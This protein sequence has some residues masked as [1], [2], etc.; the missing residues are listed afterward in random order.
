[1]D[2]EVTEEL[3]VGPADDA[4]AEHL[5]D[6]PGW[7]EY[8]ARL[9]DTLWKVVKTTGVESLE[10]GNLLV[11]EPL[12]TRHSTLRNG[13]E[14]G[15]A[16]AISMVV[17]MLA[18]ASPYCR[19]T[20]PGLQI[21]VGFNGYVSI[22]ITRDSADKLAD[23]GR[24]VLRLQWC[25]RMPD[26]PDAGRLVEASADDI[27]WTSI[28]SVVETAVVLLCERWAHGDYGCNWFL[29]NPDNINEIRQSV[30]PRSLLC[31]AIDPDPH[32][33]PALME[34]DF[35]AFRAPLTSGRLTYAAYHWGADDLKEL[36][37]QGMNFMIAT[38]DLRE[39][40]VVPDADGV[41]RG[42]WIA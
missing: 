3:I 2:R 6:A 11:P 10:V 9:R 19:F 33:N 36:A 26:F 31:V 40:A 38:S 21:S 25:N 28:R 30:Q 7:E 13:V 37:D 15:P 24:E 27:F 32:L 29:L 4:V 41:V 1:M 22:Y 8:S 42:V 34:E 5:A 35:T 39:S 12:P 16:E 14:L 17:D 20:A 23:L 18:G